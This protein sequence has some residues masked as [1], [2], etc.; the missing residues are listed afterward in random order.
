MIGNDIVDLE[1]AKCNSRWQEQRFLD[2]LFN[3]DEQDFIRSDDQ[4]FQNIWRL[5]TMK[6]SVY[7]I[8]SRAGGRVR[9]N[10]KDFK[11]A[12]INSIQG[13][14]FYKN[15]S[16]STFTKTHQKFIQT[17]AFLKSQWTSKIFQFSSADYNAQHSESVRHAS[18]A[19]AAYKN[20]PN[21]SVTII[22][23]PTGIPQFYIN[24]EVQKEQLSLT[25]HGHYGACAFNV[26]KS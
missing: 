9:F 5:W 4:Q 7:K 19:Y 18:K 20:V 25:H 12:V 6:E 13:R 1:F 14:V 15:V 3:T 17:T 21:K 24:G 11:C 23:N 8:T 2:K 26:L 22:K 10:P 16:V